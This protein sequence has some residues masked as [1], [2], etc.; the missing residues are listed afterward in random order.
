MI[1]AT[2]CNF[3]DVIANAVYSYI[4]SHSFKKIIIV[5]V[6]VLLPCLRGPFATV[7]NVSSDAVLQADLF[8]YS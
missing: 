1:T 6:S 5:F 3:K 4:I 2:Y 8:K 7:L